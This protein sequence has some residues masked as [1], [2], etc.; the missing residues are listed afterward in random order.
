[1]KN[2][3]DTTAD[4]IIKVFMSGLDAK[5]FDKMKKEDWRILPTSGVLWLWKESY[6]EKKESPLWLAFEYNEQ[7][8]IT[9]L[10]FGD[11][12]IKFNQLKAFAE[13]KKLNL[14]FQNEKS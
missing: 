12:G 6:I 1:M 11:N 7:G 13:L 10:Q 14:S 4:E 5:V 9:F 2:F 3:N 8:E